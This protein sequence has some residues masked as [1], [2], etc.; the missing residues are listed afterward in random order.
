MSEESSHCLPAVHSRGTLENL[1][2]DRVAGDLEHLAVSQARDCAQFDEL[3]ILDT[4]SPI[5]EHE[6][7]HDFTDCSVILIHGTPPVQSCPFLTE[8]QNPSLSTS[9][10]CRMQQDSPQECP[11]SGASD[12][13]SD[14]HRENSVQRHTPR[15]SLA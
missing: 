14:R 9:P 6:R 11:L 15:C 10:A 8:Y 13:D 12:L 5:Q 3:T 7:P 1:N 2:Q 4:L